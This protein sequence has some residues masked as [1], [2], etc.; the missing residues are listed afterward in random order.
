M[1]YILNVISGT[2]PPEQQGG[3]SVISPLP[4]PPIFFVNVSFFRRALEVPFLKEVT[5]NAHEN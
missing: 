4:L 5:K 1:K 3:C 2:G